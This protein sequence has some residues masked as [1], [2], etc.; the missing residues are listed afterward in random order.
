MAIDTYAGKPLYFWV[1]KVLP[2]VYDDSLS[3]YELLSKAVLKLNELIENNNELPEYIKT[4]IATQL[5]S[6]EFGNILQGV[7]SNFM[8]NVKYPPTGIT[9]A[10]GDGA[11]DDT[12]AIQDCID[13]AYSKGGG[14]VY[15]PSGIYL[16]KPIELKENV[17]LVG[18]DRYKTILTLKGGATSPLVT[19]LGKN[20][21]ANITLNGNAGAQTYYQSCLKTTGEDHLIYSCILD[22]GKY[23]V[24]DTSTG[25][26]QMSDIIVP[27]C[28]VAGLYEYGSAQVEVENFLVE[29]V[30]AVQGDAGAIINNDNGTYQIG[31]LGTVDEGVKL[32]GDRN[33]VQL[34]SVNPT[35]A[36]TDNGTGNE[37]HVEGQV[38]NIVQQAMSDFENEINTII[39][40]YPVYNSGDESLTFKK[41]N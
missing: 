19:A 22:G 39:D 12:D 35:V 8:L 11:T 37:I 18:F 20:T 17:A 26:M 2:L 25:H 16:T 7:I 38:S 27:S 3:Y 31:V 41:I 5:Q 24:E 6:E 9:P 40:S 21:V 33:F 36:Y 13:Y 1:Q 34:R 10:E 15:I 29:T 14:A 4:E 28:L 23:G 30:S 32:G